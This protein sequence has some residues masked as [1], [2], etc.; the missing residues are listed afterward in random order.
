MLE[1]HHDDES[2]IADNEAY[3]DDRIEPLVAQVYDLCVARGIPFVVSFEYKPHHL[4]TSLHKPP[5]C[6]LQLGLGAEVLRHGTGALTRAVAENLG[7][8]GEESTDR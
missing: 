7:I 8:F 1:C 6:C 4:V 3:I 5:G 2:P